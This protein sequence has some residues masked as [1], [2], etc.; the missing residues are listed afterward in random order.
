VSAREIGMAVVGSS[1]HG[2][3]V[4]APTIDRTP[5]AQLRAVLG[6][7]E[8]RG[9]ALADTYDGCVAHADL[10]TLLADANVDALWIASPNSTHVEFATAAL[11]AGKHVLVEKPMA[12]TSA[13]AAALSAL[14]DQTGLTFKVAFQHRFRPP[15]AW[16]REAVREQR[17]GPLSLLRIHRFWPYPYFPD[18]PPTPSGWRASLEGSGGWVLNDIGSHL[19][20]LALWLAGEEASLAFAKTANHKFR[21]AEGEDT[22]TVLLELESGGLVTVETSNAFASFPG[23]IEIHGVDGWLRADGTFDG[24]GS[25]LTSG[26]ERIDFPAVAPTAVADACLLDFLTAIEG[27]PSQGATAAEGAATVAIVEQ[28]ATR[29]A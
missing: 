22:A 21:D 6:S 25:V 11:Q 24:E 16:L 3:R 18:M 2:A 26:G 20:D 19:I 12:T 5:R 17:V 7:S 27:G 1:G 8:E 13:D 29:D 15:H 10:T 9:R 14:A 4:S 28:A 23:T